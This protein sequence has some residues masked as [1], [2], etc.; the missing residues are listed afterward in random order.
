MIFS[1]KYKRCGML[2]QNQIRMRFILVL[3]LTVAGTHIFWEFLLGAAFLLYTIFWGR[4]PILKMFRMG[5]NQYFLRILPQENP[6]PVL[7]FDNEG[8]LLFQ[9]DMAKDTLSISSDIG[10]IDR[11]KTISDIPAFIEKKQNIS[12]RYVE[13]DKIWLVT[14]VGSKKEELLFT[15]FQDMSDVHRIQE[16]ILQTQKDIIYTMGEI[17]ETRS[18]ETGNHVKRVAEYSYLLGKLGGLDDDEAEIL[19][20]AS[21]MH[22]IGKV[23]IPDAILNKPGKLDKD[24]YFIMKTHAK[25][26]YEMLNGSDRPILQAAA[27]VAY[28]HHEKW[29]GGGYP[30]NIK[31]EEIHIYGRITALSD[32]FDALG[33]DRV[34]KK[35]WDLPKILDL[36]KEEKGKHFDPVLVDIFILNLDKFLEIRDT[37]PG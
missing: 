36:L 1:K 26:G 27:I 30:R 7:V 19:K 5:E 22:D 2:S 14:I 10:S 17:G 13:E 3:I 16:E 18:K 24:E 33:S 8:G 34:Y 29:D 25:L 37:F 23:G 20:M 9:N 28:E 31:G 35:A 11:H 12:L 4:C 15:Y 21:P 6:T 32:V